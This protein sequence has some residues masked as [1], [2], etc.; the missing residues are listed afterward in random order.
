MTLTSDLSSES[1]TPLTRATGNVY[2]DFDFSTFFVGV[3][4]E[5]VQERHTDGWARR[6]L[7]PIGRTHNKQLHSVNISACDWPQRFSDK[8]H[9][10]TLLSYA[11]RMYCA[12]TLLLQ[13]DYDWRNASIVTVRSVTGALSKRIRRKWRIVWHILEHDLVTDQNLSG[14]GTDCRVH[15]RQTEN[16]LAPTPTT[17][18]DPSP[19][20]EWLVSATPKRIHIN[21]HME[22]SQ[23]CK[24][25]YDILLISRAVKLT[26]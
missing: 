23:C 24:T 7:R 11:L 1:G 12:D 20:P 9:Y 15:H 10:N 22:I 14:T 18:P 13:N 3:T 5:P 25:S 8:H 2:A 4:Y 19:L 17:A 26:R 6:V 21:Q 16:D